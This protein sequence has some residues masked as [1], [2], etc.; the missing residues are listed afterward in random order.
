ME[1]ESGNIIEES[2]FNPEKARLFVDLNHGLI[3]SMKGDDEVKFCD[4]ESGDPGML[5]RV[6]LGGR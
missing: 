4:V 6:T 2:V 3:S 5:K 1:L